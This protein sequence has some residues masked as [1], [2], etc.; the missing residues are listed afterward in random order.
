MGSPAMTTIPEALALAVN[1]H[2]A[3]DLPRA[4]GL[5]RQI[6]R[7]D[8][9]HAD[10]WH[11][12][13][14]IA[15]Q[16]GQHAAAVE[17]IN[18]AIALNPSAAVYHSNLSE[19]QRSLGRID[20][21]IAC[22]RRAL[23]LDP[24]YIDANFNLGLNVGNLMYS[25]GRLDEAVDWY[26]QAIAARPD[27]AATHYNLGNTL[28]DLGRPDEAVICFRRAIELK[29]D[30]VEAVN[31]LAGILLAQGNTA[32]A[33]HHYQ[34]A[35]AARP[36]YAEARYNL[37]HAF[38]QQGKFDEA[39]AWYQRTLAIKPD[40]VETHFNL[41]HALQ[42]Q[43]RLDEAIS[44]Y[45]RA[46]SLR[47]EDASAHCN[48]GTALQQQG[49]L[50][51][52]VASYARALELRSEY[53]E[54]ENNL[55]IAMQEQGKLDEALVRSRRAVEF[56]PE[57][58]DAHVTLGVVLAAHGRDE[59]AIASFDRALR[60]KMHP[61]AL[62]RKATCLPVICRS[63]EHIDEVR[64]RFAQGVN[65]LEQEG[66][67]FNPRHE[68][69]NPG[70]YLTY[71]GLNDRALHEGVARLWNVDKNAFV[72]PPRVA[73]SSDKR[74]HVGFISRFFKVHTV[75]EL[76]KGLIARLDR[77]KFRVSVFS[78]GQIN[79][80]VADFV[81]QNADHYEQL[82]LQVAV[83]GQTVAVAD[84]DILYYPDIGMDP[85]TYALAQF[86]L[87]PVQCVSWGHPVTTGLSTL[88]YFLSSELL[89][90][91]DADAHYT[92][93]LIRLKT[94]G[95]YVDRPQLPE[96]RKQRAEF[97][98]PQDKHLY[99]C[100]QSL[101]KFHPEFDSLLAEILRRDPHGILILPSGEC[102]HWND[103]WRELLVERFQATMPD[104]LDRIHWLPWQR[105][106]DYLQLTALIDVLLV[107]P[108][109]GG[110]KTSY[111]ALA[112][113]T[114]VVTLPSPYLRGRITHGLYRAIDV[115]DCI[116]GSPE[117]YIGIAVRLA[118]D[119]SFRRLVHDKILA[120]N[121]RLFEDH[122]AV[123]ELEQFF[124][125]VVSRRA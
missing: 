103:H 73:T 52:A 44:A 94:L 42:K 40:Y 75:G 47:P 101:F 12:L 85:I 23:E 1:A 71:H 93:K 14:V 25:R 57:L 15:Q 96:N 51:E 56:K 8:P 22:C 74:I 18:R 118:N 58:I 53:A 6:L 77:Q 45:R 66:V 9:N 122:Q 81:R 43:L 17:C 33:I 10:A 61:E 49:K 29:P 91:A 98:L 125:S 69:L 27:F 31:N 114:P 20:E 110:G 83:I 106:E 116:A 84:L 37:G 16:V 97:G 7:V 90:T 68:L 64:Q 38:Q 5:Y 67:R 78:L 92:E 119:E 30:L 105:H 99:A 11:L 55:A 82:P 108:Q 113:G 50:D 46:L 26:R 121:H 87:A 124:E 41:G 117:E 72:R 86:R 112:L 21:A 107:P 104:V 13:G 39:I 59:E 32:E 62:Y 54:A 2:Q 63:V 28:R 120:A 109:F 79:D 3:G 70:F 34:H 100:L 102:T 35:A 19:A 4:E 123:R 36:D 76:W 48:L 60:L 88:D 115:H 89:E 24:H 80:S 111:E 65:A 95:L